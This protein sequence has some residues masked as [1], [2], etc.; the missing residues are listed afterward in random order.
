MELTQT[1]WKLPILIASTHN[2]E[3]NHEK[4]VGFHA[5]DLSL[6]QKQCS[7]VAVSLL[8]PCSVVDELLGQ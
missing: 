8:G 6:H 1:R 5:Y 3:G 4:L 2:S 7:V